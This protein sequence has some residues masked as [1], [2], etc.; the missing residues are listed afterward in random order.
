MDKDAWRKAA[1]K[2]P[3]KP[4]AVRRTILAGSPEAPVTMAR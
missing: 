1:K 3:G 4:P 2:N